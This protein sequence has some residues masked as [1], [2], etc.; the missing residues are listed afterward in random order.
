MSAKFHDLGGRLGLPEIIEIEPTDT[1]NLRCRACH[2]SFMEHERTTLLDLALLSK[3]SGVRGR[4]AIVGSVFEPIVHPQIL[5]ILDFLSQQDHR[6]E[7]LTN[8]T[9]LDEAMVNGMASLNL[10]YLSFSFDGI[11][12]E[13]YE[14]IRRRA[15]YQKVVE[16]ILRV[17]QRFEGRPTFFNLNYTMMRR[18]IDEVLAATE[19][20]DTHGFDAM[21]FIFVVIRELE[22]S[23]IDESLYPVRQ[24]AFD[25]LDEVARHV[26]EEGR[27]ITVRCPYF[28]VSPLR[29]RYPNNFEDV[30]VRSG[31]PGA[32]V[33][34]IPR[35]KIQLAD[36]PGMSF[37]C[38]S[39]FSLARILANGD[40]QLCYKVVV[41]NL[42]ESSFEDIWFGEYAHRVRM[43]RMADD[44]TC[45][46]CD[47]YRF[48]LKYN[49][50]DLDARGTHFAGNTL[51]HADATDFEHGVVLTQ[52]AP[53]PPRLVE[54]IRLYN[55]VFYDHKYFGV[56]QAAGPIDVDSD[57]ISTVDGLIVDGSLGRLRSSIKEKTGGGV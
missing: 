23:V 3:L 47:Y 15:S 45:R 24:E 8:G 16:G 29:Q 27:R 48:A 26:I 20:W 43:E 17:R 54:S 4:Y 13:T 11:R 50:M 22:R 41:G 28:R 7:L 40:V 37:Q 31:H 51:A 1:C 12:P 44:R 32:R 34:P 52:I 56:P 25:K 35:N 53:P 49:E 36:F 10:Y 21:N 33:V 18:N 57:A 46:S 9:R 14:Y 30:V 19:Y 5:N 39:P 2:V 42:G 38:R 55:I 6:V